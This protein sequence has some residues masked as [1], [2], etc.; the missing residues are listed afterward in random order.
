MGFANVQT[1]QLSLSILQLLSKKKDFWEPKTQGFH[2]KW[3][4]RI[5]DG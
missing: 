1:G 5:Q 2:E 4:P 3:I